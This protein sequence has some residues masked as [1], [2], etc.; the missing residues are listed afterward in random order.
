MDVDSD[1]EDLIPEPIIIQPIA[2]TDGPDGV[3]DDAV[4][5]DMSWNA[6]SV[7]LDHDYISY[8]TGI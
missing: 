7:M 1:F 8:F 2:L 6:Y 3:T 5:E 4:K